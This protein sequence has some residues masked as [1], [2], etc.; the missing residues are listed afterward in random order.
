MSEKNDSLKRWVQQV[1]KLETVPWDLL[2]ELDL[3]MDQVITLMNRQLSVMSA[4]SD[5]PL[6]SGMINNYVKDC[7]M[8]SPVKKKYNREHLTVLLIICMLKSVFSMPQI[9]D[10]IE[11]ISQLGSSEQ[12]YDT[13]QRLQRQAL[14]EA[15]ERVRAAGELDEPDR[16]LLAMELALEANAKRVAAARLLSSVVPDQNQKPKKEKSEKQKK[17]KSSAK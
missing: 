12:L 10:L 3:Y 9:R 6:T 1:D 17:D 15:V 5:R 4:D 11:R 14:Q 13:F 2:P 16:C 7:V 8:P